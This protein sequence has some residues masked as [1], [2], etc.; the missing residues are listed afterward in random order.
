MTAVVIDNYDSFTFNLYQL[1]AAIDRPP[2]VFRNDQISVRDLVALAPSAIILSPGPGD[3]SE[4]QR[5]GI[6]RDVITQ[7][8]RDVPVLGVCLGHQGIVHAFG[9][10]IVRAPQPMHGKTSVIHHRDRGLFAGLPKS[11]TAMRYHSLAADPAQLPDCLEVD[12]WTDDGVNMAVR[13]QRWPVYG[14]QFHPESIETPLGPT[15][16]RRFLQRA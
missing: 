4:V 13:H 12:A 9:G 8:G 3:P 2:L 1:I 16:M 6:C 11:F 10:K 14:V 7:L 15:L 5:F